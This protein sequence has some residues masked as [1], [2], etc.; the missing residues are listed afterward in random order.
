MLQF[1]LKY[2]KC[3][4]LSSEG[5]FMLPEAKGRMSPARPYK[6]HNW[7][8]AGLVSSS[9]LKGRTWDINHFPIVWSDVS[10]SVLN[11][12]HPLP[13][14][15]LKKPTNY[16]KP[17]EQGWSHQFFITVTDDS[18][19]KGITTERIPDL[20]LFCSCFSVY[21][22]FFKNSPILQSCAWRKDWEYLYQ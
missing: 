15:R 8:T 2:L 4:S 10:L 13:K 1:C 11:S 9:H 18:Y 7:D 3:C 20:G 16:G 5:Q 12:V 6:A 21:S 22:Y 19:L 14:T 17:T